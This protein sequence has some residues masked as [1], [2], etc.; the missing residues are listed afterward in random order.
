MNIKMRELL[1]KEVLRNIEKL[2]KIREDS[3][4]PVEARIEAIRVMLEFTIRD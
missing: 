4:Y 2:T 1:Q 3:G